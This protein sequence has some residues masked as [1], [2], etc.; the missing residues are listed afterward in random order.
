MPIYDCEC[1]K[2][3]NIREEFLGIDEEPKEI[4]DVCGGENAYRLPGG[5]FKLVYNPKKDIC[6]WQ[7]N[8][9]QRYK[10]YHDAKAEGKKI[11]LPDGS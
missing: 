7:G 8:T 9:T 4:C 5:N 11:D 3:G 1:K 10:A 2:C 6:D